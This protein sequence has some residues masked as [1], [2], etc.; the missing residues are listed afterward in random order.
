M[1][2]VARISTVG[3]AIVFCLSVFYQS[4]FALSCGNFKYPKCDGPDLQ[5]A[6]GFDPQIGF[7]GFGGGACRA[8]RTPV[9]FIH[10]NGDR[11]TNWDSPVVGAVKNYPAPVRSVYQE[12]KARGYNDCELFGITYL[13]ATEQEAPKKNYHKPEKYDVLI[14]FIEAVKSYTGKKQVD[15][16]AHSLGVSMAL[17]A[18]AYHDKLHSDKNGWS[19]V[20]R[21]VNIA[22]GVRGLPACLAVGFMNPFVSTCGSQNIFNSYVFGFYPDSG[23]FIGYND[24]TGDTG[25]LSLRRMPSRYPQVMFYTL[26]AGLHDQI[27]CSTIERFMECGRGASFAGY[28]NVKAQLNLGAGTKPRKMNFDFQQWR[29][30]AMIGGDADGVGHF[31]VRNNTGQII[32]EMLNTDCMGLACKGAYTGGPVAALQE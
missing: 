6:G 14:H 17:A 22:G 15:I 2:H 26:S 23:S 11:A 9:I 24:W 4:A 31:K 32:Y 18:L 1:R 12:F 3:L 20:R 25:P 13:S 7:G 10:G 16:V 5:Y 30:T 27:H 19:G 8:S 21:F 29:P 28:R